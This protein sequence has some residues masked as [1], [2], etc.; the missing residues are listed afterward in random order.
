M[1]TAALS[2]LAWLALGACCLPAR[3]ATTALK[4]RDLLAQGGEDHFWIAQVV[5]SSPASPFESTNLAYRE[6]FGGPWTALEQSIS[7]RVV[8]LASQEGELLLVLE[9]G[10]W[11]IADE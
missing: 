11:M 7:S 10:Q 9:D 5:S 8:S 1:R 3:A 4:A 2:L 6:D